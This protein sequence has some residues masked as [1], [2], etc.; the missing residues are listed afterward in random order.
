MRDL[1]NKYDAVIGLEV[2]VQLSTQ[3]KAFSSDL[4]RFGTDPNTNVSV[5]SLGHPGVLPKF[6]QK[7]LEYAILI[8][9]VAHSEIA[10][11][12]N[13]SRKNYFYTDLPKGYQISQHEN[14]I[15]SNGYLTIRV[16]D[17]EKR[18]NL[19]RIHIEED[20]GK[21]IHDQD[22]VHTLIDLNR[23]GIPLLEIVTAPDISSSE[24]AYQFLT[25]LR[26]LVRYLEIS[27]GNMEEGSLRCDAN[28]SV[29]L[30]NTEKLGTRTEIKN[31]NSISQVKKAIEYEVM[32][33]INRVE[34]GQQVIQQTLLY[35]ETTGNTIPLRI[36][37][38]AHDY[39]YFPD[40]DLNP[41]IIT[42]E[43]IQSIKNRLPVLPDKLYEKFTTQYH[44]SDYDAVQLIDDKNIAAYFEEIIKHTP[45][46]KS[47]ANWV[48]GPV[49]AYLNDHQTVISDFPLKPKKIADLIHIVESKQVS[50]TV[51]AQKL[52]HALIQTPESDPLEVAKMNNWLQVGEEDEIM[53][54]VNQA[55]HKY[56]EKI[57]EYHKGKKGLLGLFMGEVMKLS[58][59]KVDPEK[60]NNLIKKELEKRKDND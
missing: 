28:V 13:F 2:H 47:A 38:E 25:V 17:H 33:Q 22:P 5:I 60:A 58:D 41:V 49:K 48:M 20:A 42:D 30:K 51:A 40:P 12:V 36:K 7:V 39:R 18:I 14:P 15:C 37:E 43:Y 11:T 32:R 27:D 8:G 21:S 31:L 35:D 3:S 10:G 46:I 1:F 24:E 44:L 4:N 16:N 57:K 54:M 34:Y 59:G 55:L 45:H 9:L 29:K 56:P 19:I 53:K 50:I 6:N 26:R 23:S 52:F